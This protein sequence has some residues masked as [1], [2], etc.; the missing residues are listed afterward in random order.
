MIITDPLAIIDFSPAKPAE[1]II[2]ELSP[3]ILD[4]VIAYGHPNVLGT[5]PTTLE[6]TKEDFLTL[7]GT[8]IIGIN[9]SKAANDLNEKL[10]KII[11]SGKEI[12]VFLKAGKFWDVF[13][14]FGDSNLTLSNSIS[15]V[16]RRSTF[17]SDRT[18]LIACLKSAKDISR[19]LVQS[20][21]DPNQMLEIFFFT[22]DRTEKVR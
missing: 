17:I 15:I 6:V 18:V 14:G 12:G 5:H 19:N 3:Y 1:D 4:K 8:C 7:R 22:F 11:Q 21:Q 2:T 20:L 10:K 13:S 9:A 16:F